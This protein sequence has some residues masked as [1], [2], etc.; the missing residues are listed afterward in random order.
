M[1]YS[2]LA[3]HTPNGNV[4]ARLTNIGVGL[5]TCPYCNFVQCWNLKSVHAPDCKRDLLLKELP[6]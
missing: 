2:D 6:E 3:L 5:D 1:R 4:Y